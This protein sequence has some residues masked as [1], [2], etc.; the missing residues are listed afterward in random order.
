MGRPDLLMSDV[1]LPDGLSGF[2]IARNMREL[3][4]GLKVLFVSGYPDSA[5]K[6]EHKRATSGDDFELLEK[7][8]RKQQLAERIIS[9][10]G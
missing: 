4:H 10:L 7:P 8:F 1:M 6:V 5:R 3:H 9:I 2:D